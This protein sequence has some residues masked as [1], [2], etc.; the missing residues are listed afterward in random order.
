MDNCLSRESQQHVDFSILFQVKS[1]VRKESLLASGASLRTA[2]AAWE[3]G[4]HAQK[5]L[6][7]V[8]LLPECF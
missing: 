1:L 4:A 2:K 3:A 8:T 7:I 6:W 5:G